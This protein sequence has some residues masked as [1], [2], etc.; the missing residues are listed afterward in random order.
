MTAK[1]AVAQYV[2]DGDTVG[3]GGQSIGRCSM[4]LAHEVIRQNKTDLTLVGCNMAMHMDL[5]VG[6]GAVKK[7]ESGTGN[8]ER[9]GTAFQWRKAI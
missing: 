4:A 6:A 2:S 8:L 9:Y 1:E 3:I 7:T 5:L